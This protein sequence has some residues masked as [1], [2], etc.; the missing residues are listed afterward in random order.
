MDGEKIYEHP[1]FALAQ[2]ARVNSSHAKPLFGS[3]IGHSN[4]IELRIYRAQEIRSDGSYDRYFGREEY[5][6]IEMSSTQ[7]AELIT[8][9]NYG[10]GV[11]VTLRQFNGQRTD[12]PPVKNKRQQHSQEFKEK[13]ADFAKTLEEGQAKL[14]TLLKKQKLSAE[15]KRQMKHMFE[16]LSTNIKSNIPYFERQFE[17]QMD[18]T[19]VEAKGEVEAFIT[20]AVQ[21]TGL[22]EMR[23][24]GKF[25]SIDPKSDE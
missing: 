2:F 22:E 19:V 3:S 12:D 10:S 1:S 13:M 24:Q 14:Q 8:S 15:D 11:P 5:I 25:L 20:N 21:Q 4:T 17:E 7:F 9:M 16:F 23:K 6:K 18:Q